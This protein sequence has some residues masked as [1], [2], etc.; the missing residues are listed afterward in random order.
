MTS[1][2]WAEKSRSLAAAG[3]I[4]MGRDAQLKI[5]GLTNLDPLIEAFIKPLMSPLIKPLMN[6]LTNQLTN[7]KNEANQ[8]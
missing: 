7:T 6:P 2:S 8:T 3:L 5:E 4:V 1:E